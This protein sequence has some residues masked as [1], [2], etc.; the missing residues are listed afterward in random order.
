MVPSPFTSVDEDFNDIA[1]NDDDV[2][3][4]FNI[5][6]VFYVISST[7]LGFCLTTKRN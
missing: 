6:L 2:I 5:V 7:L 1:D 4:I 3:D